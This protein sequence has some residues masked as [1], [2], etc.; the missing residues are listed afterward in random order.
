MR[1]CSH[2]LLSAVLQ[3]RAT[4]PLLWAPA[5]YRSITPARTALSSKPA[6]HRGCGHMTG[7]TD[8]FTI[9]VKFLTFVDFCVLA[10][11]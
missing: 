9:L 3:P 11:D 6:A 2:L 10:S 1:H 4:A 5:G 8:N 7:Q